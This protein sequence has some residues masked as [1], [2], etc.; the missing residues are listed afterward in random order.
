MADGTKTQNQRIL[1]HMQAGNSI[2]FWDAVQDFGVM[3]LP[4][5]I[6]DIRELGHPIESQFV[7][8]EN[9]KRFKEYWMAQNV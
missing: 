5:R 6:K 7:K 8:G 2:T 3:H 9:G 1:N 4:R